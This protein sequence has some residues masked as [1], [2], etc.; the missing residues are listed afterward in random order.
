LIVVTSDVVGSSRQT[1]L[2]DEV[3]AGGD[4]R[5]CLVAHLVACRRRRRNV[6]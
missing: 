3:A 2:D 6:Q 1:S 5:L 4:A